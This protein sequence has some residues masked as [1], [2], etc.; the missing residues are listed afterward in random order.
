MDGCAATR[1]C[2]FPIFSVSFISACTYYLRAHGRNTTAT[3]SFMQSKHSLFIYSSVSEESSMRSSSLHILAIVSFLG[4][5]RS[6]FL[7][8]GEEAGLAESFRYASSWS[9]LW[10]SSLLRWKSSSILSSKASCL[11]LFSPSILSLVRL[12][13]SPNVKKPDL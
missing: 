11:L 3:S 6:E 12:N 13:S 1:T 4:M 10:M 9:S 7:M 8:E 2:R 5:W